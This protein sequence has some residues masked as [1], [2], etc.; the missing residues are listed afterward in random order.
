MV[1]KDGDFVNGTSRKSPEKQIQDF[2]SAFKWNILFEVISLR[3][4]SPFGPDVFVREGGVSRC[5]PFWHSTFLKRLDPQETVK[6][7][8]LFRGKMKIII[9]SK[10]LGPW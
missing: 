5:A 8:P 10:V 6:I 1:V 3:V 9:D 2:L 7:S 4:Q